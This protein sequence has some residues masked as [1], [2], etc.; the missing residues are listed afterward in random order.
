MANKMNKATTDTSGAS[1][2]GRLRKAE[3]L[4][5]GELSDAHNVDDDLEDVYENFPGWNPARW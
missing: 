5:T 3:P 4:R 2:A 1:V